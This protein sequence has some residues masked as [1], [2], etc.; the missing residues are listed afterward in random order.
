MDGLYVLT[1]AV[2]C[3]ALVVTSIAVQVRLRHLKLSQRIAYA[4]FPLS[5]FLIIGILLYWVISLDYPEATMLH[6]AIAAVVCC[7]VDVALFAKLGQIQDEELSVLRVKLLAEQLNVQKKYNARLE[8]DYEKL[9][10][11]KSGLL[12]ELEHVSSCIAN[13]EGYG[14]LCAFEPA[15]GNGSANSDADYAPELLHFCDHPIVDVV[16]DIKY[17]ECQQ[18]GVEPRFAL[19]I[20]RVVPS[21]PDAEL[22]AVFSN[23]LDNAIKAAMPQAEMSESA[24]DDASHCEA[25]EAEMSAQ[26]HSDRVPYVEAVARTQGN[27]LLIKVRNSVNS[28][29]AISVPKEH[30]EGDRCLSIKR[31]HGWGLSII[32]EIATRHGGTLVTKSAHGAFE[33]SVVLLAE[34]SKAA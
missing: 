18:A 10:G 8:E 19:D 30:D 3:A 14:A 23:L 25:S 9:E 24:K 17:R 33:A 22:C 16:A 13:G 1:A 31:E 6:V 32:E 29:E 5:Q 26:G 11:I 20:P 7:I 2:S 4:L 12:A 21:I 15:G 27:V 34:E 28:P